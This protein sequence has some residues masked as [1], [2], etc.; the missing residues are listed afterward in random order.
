MDK[1]PAVAHL[2]R[3]RR[4][5]WCEAS[6]FSSARV[7]QV[8]E[9]LREAVRLMEEAGREK[10]AVGRIPPAPRARGTRRGREWAELQDYRR[11]ACRRSLQDGPV[12]LRAVRGSVISRDPKKVR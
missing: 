7:L 1:P 11:R 8:P 10:L 5:E 12:H 2:P 4:A 9:A 3:V 6:R